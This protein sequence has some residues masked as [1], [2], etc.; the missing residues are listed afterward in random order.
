MLKLSVN[1]S[2]WAMPYALF[3]LLSIAMSA[4]A[5]TLNAAPPDATP[6]ASATGSAVTLPAPAA[7]L[8][9]GANSPVPAITS[10]SQTVRLEFVSGDTVARY[11]V[12]EQLARI[13]FPS[14]AIGSTK[15]VTGTIVASTDGTIS[16]DSKVQVDLSTLSSNE[17][18]HD[19][20]IKGGTLQTSTYPYATFVPTA[21]QGLIL[22]PQSGP[23]SFKLTG[24]LTIKNVT[25]PVSWDVTGTIDGNEAT[26]RVSTTFTFDY[27]NLQKP[28]VG[29]V[30]SVD[31]NIKL[32]MDIHL[33]RVTTQ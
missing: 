22:P 13:N 11:L 4:C 17:S 16:P 31:D 12:R 28:N 8:T 29:A 25:K 6:G 21:I 9:P 20:F 2:V 26:G 10:N 23:V 14:D 33:R 3:L 5:P 7:A 15:A 24:N 1:S 18:G 27:F 30:L 19:R 32:E